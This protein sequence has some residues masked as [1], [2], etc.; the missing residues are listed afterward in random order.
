MTMERLLV[1][2]N[3]EVMDAKLKADVA[4]FLL[5]FFLDNPVK[6]FKLNEGFSGGK[7]EMIVFPN[8]FDALLFLQYV[9]D[10]KLA[11]ADV[12][13]QFQNSGWVSYPEGRSITA[14]NDYDGLHTYIRHG[15]DLVGLSHVVERGVV[16]HG[17]FV[18]KVHSRYL[19]DVARLWFSGASTTV[20]NC[21]RQLRYDLKRP[22]KPRAG[23]IC[24]EEYLAPTVQRLDDHVKLNVFTKRG[25]FYTITNSGITVGEYGE[26]EDVLK[27]AVWG[28]RKFKHEFRE[29]DVIGTKHG[30][31]SM[32]AAF[33][34][35]AHIAA[36]ERNE[37]GW[38]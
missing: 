9:E 20:Y 13:N 15:D 5:N 21:M 34:Q 35:A 16:K 18:N 14:Y 1:I 22:R 24:L 29:E 8:R 6:T 2:V 33:R 11:M 28:W 26:D 30:L 4:E 32:D 37:R 7:K 25:D 23:D 36:I 17:A 31:S 19:G 38:V 27:A 12:V 3:Y 10:R